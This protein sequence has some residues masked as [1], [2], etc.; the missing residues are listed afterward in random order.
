M[1]L[2]NHIGTP[3]NGAMVVAVVVINKTTNQQSVCHSNAKTLKKS[4]TYF[5]HAGGLQATSSSKG[6]VASFVAIVRLSS[7][8]LLLFMMMLFT[9]RHCSFPRQLLVSFSVDQCPVSARVNKRMQK[10]RTKLLLHFFYF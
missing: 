10:K 8:L 9:H 5:T 1:R 2:I 4:H 3:L 6:N 7:L